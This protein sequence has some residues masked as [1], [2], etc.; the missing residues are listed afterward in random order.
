MIGKDR[1]KTLHE[2]RAQSERFLKL[3]DSYDALSQ[4]DAR[5]YEQ[6]REN[7]DNFSTA[8]ITDAA[9]RRETKIARFREE[10]ALKTQIEVGS[11]SPKL[12]SPS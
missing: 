9:A 1:K 3:L 5:M 10:K 4:K 8:S 11:L 6:Y 12:R 7:P 2:S